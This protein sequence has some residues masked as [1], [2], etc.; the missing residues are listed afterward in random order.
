METQA[1]ADPE[2]KLDIAEGKG[3]NHDK[4]FVK[5]YGEGTAV[6]PRPTEG[7]REAEEPLGI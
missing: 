1:I 4:S 5:K 3:A 6:A 2:P 7:S